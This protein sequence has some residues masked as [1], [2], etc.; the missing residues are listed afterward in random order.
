M[1]ISSAQPPIQWM[2]GY[3]P[4][5]TAGAKRFNHWPPS[6]AWVKNAWS[7]TSTPPI[8]FHGVKREKFTFLSV[9]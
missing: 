5:L 9:P 4:R 2:Q 1:H 7:Y 3:F 6:F 8:C